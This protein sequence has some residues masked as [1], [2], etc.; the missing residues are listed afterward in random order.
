M[1]DSKFVPDKAILRITA[2]GNVELDG[3][4]VSKNV[5][6]QDEARQRAAEIVGGGY[7]LG[8]SRL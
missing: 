6:T 1:I 3:G 8:R 2:V 7:G 4:A 5:F